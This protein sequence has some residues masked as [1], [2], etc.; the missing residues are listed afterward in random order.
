M[1]KRALIVGLVLAL[2]LLVPL[3]ALVDDSDQRQRFGWNMYSTETYYPR[4]VLNLSTGES[5][6]LPLGQVARGLRPEI[7][8]AADL[9]PYLCERFPDAQ[10]VSLSFRSPEPEVTPCA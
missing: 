1:A 2:Q 9:P 5:H 4:I 7:N 10:S 3:R 6:A 8:Y